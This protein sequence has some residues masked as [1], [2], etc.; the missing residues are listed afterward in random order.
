[1]TQVE[2]GTGVID[3]DPWLEP[4]RGALKHRYFN[5]DLFASFT[6]NENSGTH[7]TITGYNASR[8]PKEALTNSAEDMNTLDLIIQKRK[9]VL[10]TENGHPMPLRHI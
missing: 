5:S 3:S 9:N 7:T 1:M 10:F 4:F 8:M 6:Y 2:D